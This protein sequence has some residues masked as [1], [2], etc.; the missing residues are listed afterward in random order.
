MSNA[1][2]PVVVEYRAVHSNEHRARLGLKA[3]LWQLEVYE[4]SEPDE[5]GRVYK[6]LVTVLQNKSKAVLARVVAAE[7]AGRVV[8]TLDLS[9]VNHTLF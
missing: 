3:D 5:K 1:N 4:R 9:P 2:T 7:Y 8:S 6:K